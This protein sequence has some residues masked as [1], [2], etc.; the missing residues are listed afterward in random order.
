MTSSLL[1]FEGLYAAYSLCQLLI[2][3]YFAWAIAGVLTPYF[4]EHGM[5]EEV[6]QARL[7]LS[8]LAASAV[9]A[10]VNGLATLL[11]N[12]SKALAARITQAFLL[13]CWATSIGF[14]IVTTVHASSWWRY[15]DGRGEDEVRL[16]RMAQ[17]LAGAMIASTVLGWFLLFVIFLFAAWGSQ[18]EHRVAH[19]WA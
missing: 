5:D 11:I 16:A 4:A 13:A 7:V 14:G 3:A 18:K 15:F 9:M 19:V 6:R 2:G 17:A 10:A 8:Y 1:L 12:W